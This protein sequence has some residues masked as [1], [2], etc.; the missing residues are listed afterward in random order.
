[1]PFKS[2]EIARDT[3]DLFLNYLKLLI[4]RR[5]EKF[6][7]AFWAKY[8]YAFDIPFR[9]TAKEMEQCRRRFGEGYDVDQLERMFPSALKSSTAE[10]RREMLKSATSSKESSTEPKSASTPKTPVDQFIRLDRTKMIR[11]AKEK[12]QDDP[13]SIISKDIRSASIRSK[14]ITT[15]SPISIVGTP[16]TPTTPSRLRP[17]KLNRAAIL[18]ADAIFT[19]Y[20]GTD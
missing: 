3:S 18:R 13:K 12:G 5:K 17:I 7:E 11:S 1:L 19:R 9:L 20:W 15:S 10:W 16:S 8:G 14:P 2:K 4:L 6:G